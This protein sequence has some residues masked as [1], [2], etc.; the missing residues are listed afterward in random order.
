MPMRWAMRSSGKCESEEEFLRQ[1]QRRNCCKHSTVWRKRRHG[2]GSRSEKPAP[3]GS[4]RRGRFW[5]RYCRRFRPLSCLSWRGIFHEGWEIKSKF[6][7]GGLRGTGGLLLFPPVRAHL[8]TTLKGSGISCGN[9]ALCEANAAA[10]A[11]SRQCHSTCKCCCHRLRRS[12]LFPFWKQSAPCPHKPATGS[13]VCGYDPMLDFGSFS[14]LR[15]R[16]RKRK[17]EVNKI[18]RFIIWKRK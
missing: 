15:K 9:R 14:L 5:R 16:N 12:Q 2:I 17:N 6:Q 10:A 4:F 13:F 8:L 7:I 11:A 18:W 3:A 1:R